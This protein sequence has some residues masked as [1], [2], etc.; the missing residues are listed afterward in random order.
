L[1][2]DLADIDV[3]QRGHMEM[4]I[5]ADL[6]ARGLISGDVDPS[7]LVVPDRKLM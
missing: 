6:A 7:E 1:T 3:C 5:A 4:D 2:F